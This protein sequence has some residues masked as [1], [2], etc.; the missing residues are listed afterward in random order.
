L[1]FSSKTNETFGLKIFWGFCRTK[2]SLSSEIFLGFE[3]CEARKVLGVFCCRRGGGYSVVAWACRR[4]LLGFLGFSV[5]GVVVVIR[6]WLGL[7]GVVFWVFWG[8]LLP[9]WWWLFGSGLGL[10]VWR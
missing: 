8:F 9:A 4:G 3:R 5:V 7:A 6:W 2:I 10:P 1:G